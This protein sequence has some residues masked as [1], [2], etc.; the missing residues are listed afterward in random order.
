MITEMKIDGLVKAIA[1]SVAAGFFGEP[2]FI[3]AIAPFI[4]G[5]GTKRED[6]RLGAKGNKSSLDYLRTIAVQLTT[7]VII[8]KAIEAY[9]QSGA[10]V[11]VA[12]F[13]LGY[14]L[15]P[16]LGRATRDVLIPI[17]DG[18]TATFGGNTTEERVRNMWRQHLAERT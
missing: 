6:T 13:L 1:A 5:R 12:L 18:I 7:I 16:Y 3:Y 17:E 9:G 4:L 14:F 15:P 11:G 10:A 8:S 2:Q